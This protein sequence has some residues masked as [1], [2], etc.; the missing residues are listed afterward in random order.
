M[1]AA[2][3]SIIIWTTLIGLIIS[4]FPV[5]VWSEEI[6]RPRIKRFRVVAQGDEFAVYGEL[7]PA[8]QPDIEA[9]ILAGVPTTFEFYVYLKRVRWYWNNEIL[10]H[11]TYRHQVTYDTLRKTYAV[12]IDRVGEDG[13][14]LS[15]ITGSRQRMQEL[16]TQFHGSVVYPVHDLDPD[17]QYYVSLTASLTT[18]QLPSP[19]DHILFFLSNDF[20]TETSRKF[21]PE[22]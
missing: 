4:F 8:F 16:M 19:W 11:A 2:L 18:R 7:F 5:P 20:K 10:A 13:I 15:E 22:H 21:F 14:I 3:S 12:V 17:D 6:E 9:S 1:K